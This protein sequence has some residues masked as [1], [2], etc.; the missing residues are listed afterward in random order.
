M[1]FQT[2]RWCVQQKNDASFTELVQTPIHSEPFLTG[3]QYMRSST[4]TY[5]LTSEDTFTRFLCESG[6]YNTCG[7]GIAKQY[8]N[9]SI[10]KMFSF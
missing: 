10:G 3:N 8:V 9:I 1:G 5:N 2:I 7:S 4:I 6:D